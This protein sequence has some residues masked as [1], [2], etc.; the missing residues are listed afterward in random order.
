MQATD[1]LHSKRNM[2]LI[3]GI[4]LQLMAVAAAFSFGYVHNGLLANADSSTIL[5]TLQ[6][7]LP[8]FRAALLG[9]LIV[10]VTDVLVAWALHRFF[11][12]NGTALSQLTAWL[13]LVYV[14]LLAAA[15]ASLFGVLA[16]TTGIITNNTGSLLV[17][18]LQTFELTW[19]AG[20]IVFGGHLLGLGVLVLRATTPNWIG[21]LLLVAGASYTLIH[22]GKLLAPGATSIIDSVEMVLAAPM[23][24]AELSLAVWLI[25]RG[26]RAPRK[27]AF[28]QPIQQP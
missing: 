20:L 15:I 28:A 22:T 12:Q 21:W 3:A 14:A 1:S 24:L 7:A 27:R 13:R 9:W 23:A 8:L 18:L 5:T 2:A 19:S 6:Q 11:R 16:A 4:S 26:G 17:W 10:L 25:A